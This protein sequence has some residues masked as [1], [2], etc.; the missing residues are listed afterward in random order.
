MLR[1][2]GDIRLIR[3]KVTFFMDIMLVFSKI[4][5][6]ERIYFITFAK[7]LKRKEYAEEELLFGIG[8]RFERQ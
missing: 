3:S 4:L 8:S 6:V 7:K 1:N 5:V 2:L